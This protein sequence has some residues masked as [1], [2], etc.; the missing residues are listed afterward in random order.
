MTKLGV[1]I[2]HYNRNYQLQLDTVHD[3]TPEG[4]KIVVCDDGSDRSGWQPQEDAI[5]ISGPNLGV[6]AN[7]NRGLYALTGS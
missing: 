5:F 3:T 4:T 2:C 6:A 1:A 7:K